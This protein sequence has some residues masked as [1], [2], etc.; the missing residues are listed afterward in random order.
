MNFCAYDHQ[1][2][3]RFLTSALLA[4]GH[5]PTRAS[6]ADLLLLD[7]DDPDAPIRGDLIDA[8]PGA[9]LLYPHDALP[10]YHGFYE[11]DPRISGQLVHGPGTASL[12]D[13]LGLERSV[14]VLGWSYSPVVPFAAPKRVERVLF[15]PIH[16][17][18]SG[19]L[20][21]VYRDENRRVFDALRALDLELTVQM[22]GT[23]GMNGL[24]A[25][26][27]VRFVE[28]SLAVDWMEID[29]ADLVVADGTFACLALARG[30]PVIMFG[31]SLPS[32]DGHDRPRLDGNARVRVPCYP[33]DFADGPLPDLFAAAC[34]DIGAGWREEY[35]GGP[36][37]PAAFAD[38]AES[39]CDTR[40]AA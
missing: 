6:A 24:P 20:D 27:Q 18:G 30:K 5:Q 10:T 9:V 40:V 22:F 23:P 21:D 15:G 13:A 39:F 31:Q 2:K 34:A 38:L 3:A 29:R 33:V 4:H 19:A 14:H 7:I 28:S 35:V 36:F 8:C 17:C 1:G 12:I 26:W 11:P 37:D 32:L 25:P 16:P